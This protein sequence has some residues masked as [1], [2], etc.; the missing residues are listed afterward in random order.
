[1][2]RSSSQSTPLRPEGER[3]LN[4]PILDIN[5][6]DYI[7]KI[8]AEKTWQETGKNTITLFKSLTLR[9]LLIGLNKGAELKRHKT[10]K[11]IS[12]QVLE[13]SL[14]FITGDKVT[15]LS[16]GHLITLHPKIP[17]SVES[18]AESFFLLTLAN[19]P[20]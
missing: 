14:R 19:I 3:I 17:H 1:M 11:V 15:A 5:L 10:D 12:V 4:A 16:K 8:K 9:I 7:E 20:E 18:D 2:K 13:G 6:Y